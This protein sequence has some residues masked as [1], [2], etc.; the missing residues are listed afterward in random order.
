[1][2]KSD[3][4]NRK[5][6][7]GDLNGDNKIDIVNSPKYWNVFKY[8]DFEIL[9]YVRCPNCGKFYKRKWEEVY[10]DP[11]GIHPP[12]FVDIFE[13][14]DHCG[15]SF[16]YKNLLPDEGTCVRCNDYKNYKL[17]KGCP[18]HENHFTYSVKDKPFEVVDKSSYDSKWIFYFTKGVSSPLKVERN[19]FRF[20][21]NHDFFVH[22]VDEDRISDLIINSG[23]L[24]AFYPFSAKDLCFINTPYADKFNTDLHSNIITKN[25]NSVNG[26]CDMLIVDYFDRDKPM[27]KIS[28]KSNHARDNNI[29][30]MINSLGVAD[31]TEYSSLYQGNDYSIGNQAQFPYVDFSGPIWVATHNSVMA[32]KQIMSN[33][34]YNY[35]GAIVHKQGLG[36]CG[37]MKTTTTDLFRNKTALT[38]YD[39]YKMGVV[40]HT[41]TD[42]SEGTYQ[43]Y[44]NVADNKKMTLR[45]ISKVETNLLTGNTIN[46]TYTNY[47]TYGNCEQIVSDMGGGLKTTTTATYDNIIAG[48]YYLIGLPKTH[49]VKSERGRKLLISSQEFEYY[50]DYKL[51]YSKNYTYVGSNDT[52]TLTNT[53]EYKY[54][55]TYGTLQEQTKTNNINGVS[56]KSSYTYWDTDN[57]S[58][59]TKTDPFGRTTTY[60]YDFDKRLL[61]NEVDYLGNT[62]T[63]GYDDFRR[64][65]KITSSIGTT[66]DISLIWNNEN[67]PKRIIKETTTTTGTPITTKYVD[68]FGRETRSTVVGFNG[69][70]IYNDKE[71]DNFGRLVRSSSPYSNTPLW[72]ESTYDDYD[73]LKTVTAPGGGSSTYTYSGN[74][75]SENNNGVISSK[76]TNAQGNLIS[77]TDGAG[78]TVT[79]TCRPDGQPY[80]ISAGGVVTT[81]VYDDYGRRTAVVDPST[82]TVQTIYDDAN[83]KVTQRYNSGKEI[84]TVYN[85]LGQPVSKT[86][87]DFT[88][89]YGYNNFGVF[90]SSSST[91]GTS[92]SF[93]FDQ[94]GRLWK[95]HET[96]NGKQYHETYNYTTSGKLDKI[97]YSPLNY[98]VVYKYNTNGYLY[99]LEDAG[100]NKL[101][102]INSVNAM[103][104]ETAVSLG[105]GLTTS[106]NY[107]PEG[108]LTNVRTINAGNTTLRDMSY[109]FNPVTG[110]LNSRADNKYNLSE[111]FNYDERYQLKEYGL[112]ASRQN[113]TYMPNGNI[114]HK[115]DAGAYTYD[116]SE[117]PYNL[118]YLNTPP[119]S[120]QNTPLNISYTV[121]SRPLTIDN[122]TYNAS[123]TYND[124]YDRAT[125]RITLNGAEV[126]FK[127]YLAG[128][129]YEVETAGG[130]ETKRLYLDG[131]PYSASVVLQ[132]TGANTP[133][134]YY[135]HRDYLGSITQISD[136]NGNLAAEYS[137]DAWG[138][139]CNPVNGQLYAPDAQ[140]A[141]LFGRGYTGHEH[142]NQLGLVNM[143]ARL[144]DPVLGRFLAPDPQVTDPSSFLD[145]NRYMY[146]RNNPMIYV[147]LNG[148]SFKDWWK[149]NFADPWKREWNAVF[150]NGFTVSV[151][152]N[153]QLQGGSFTVFPNAPNGMPNGG[154]FGFQTNSFKNVNLVP[155]YANYQGGFVSTQAV[156]FESK[157]RDLSSILT[158]KW[159]EEVKLWRI[160]N[161]IEKMQ[162]EEL[163]QFLRSSAAIDPVR[164]SNTSIWYKISNAL[165]TFGESTAFTGGYLEYQTSLGNVPKTK[166]SKSLIRTGS[167]IDKAN[168]YYNGYNLYQNPSVENAF[169]FGIEYI[170]SKS[171]ALN[172]YFMWYFNIAP[173]LVPEINYEGTRNGGW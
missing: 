155:V 4:E 135:I 95:A 43:Y 45:P 75:V 91:N 125:E 85:T 63:Y 114:D 119:A 52:K 144:Y 131:S 33:N 5:T 62:I 130:V 44:F 138:R 18:H 118:S 151:G 141:L 14:C 164:N 168:N 92:K 20:D 6:F 122:G 83:R 127:N 50:P 109:S 38:E 69:E 106:I 25:V 39:P 172:W 56:Q 47:D 67:N 143:N 139:M 121:K 142:L 98:D 160:D 136:K 41:K 133:Q 169:T 162:E 65:N 129:K 137:Y 24:V 40:T 72:T 147:D 21:E 171:F 64:I 3:F 104:Q 26:S 57:Y 87:P 150:G 103:G 13:S 9:R 116:L 31:K 19:S 146:A 48:D 71:F 123:F 55:P 93:E 15:K 29:S 51:H 37:F 156:N 111:T 61:Q 170:G 120:K 70:T 10:I 124:N 112:S 89:T 73:R 68:L 78:N 86:T 126:L 166:L 101:R 32:D 158:E 54:Y 53:T 58:L 22:D 99:R 28:Y 94:Q 79:Y 157:L 16:S 167:L 84:S 82:G 36:F 34:I 102:E 96:V 140:P 115:T 107:T 2:K 27:R 173:K 80:K 154:G 66:T 132:Q 35:E 12:Y 59:K 105:N 134:L 77:S 90:T 30:L 149:K 128:G 7:F 100:G 88:T 113:I 145:F 74:T 108:L 8:N 1:M 81:I 153:M 23:G 46:S 163:R 161:E 165:P 11:R 159:N 148:E 42:I 49:K 17:S 76:T 117:Q 97:Q 152:T 110:M 60:N